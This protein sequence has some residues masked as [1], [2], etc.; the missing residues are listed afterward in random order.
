MLKAVFLYPLSLI[1]AFITG[2]RN[3]MFDYKI[4][5]SKEYDVPVISVGNITVGGTGKTPHVEYFV[6]ILKEKFKVAVLSRG[7]KRKTKGFVLANEKSDANTIGDELYQIKRKFP[8]IIVAASE[9]RRKGIEKIMSL[10]EKPDVI[11]LDDAF[12]H[13]YV[14]PGMSV[15]LIDYSKPFFAEK[16]LPYGRL[17][18]SI[19]NRDRANIIIV[20]KVLNEMKPIDMRIMSKKLKLFP[21]QS[22][23]FSGVEYGKLSPVY[24]DEHFLL[25][26]EIIKKEN[27]SILLVTGIADA[28][29]LKNKLLTISE[30][31]VHLNYQ[32]HHSYSEGDIKKIED[33]YLKITNPKK[34]IITTEKDAVKLIDSGLAAKTIREKLYYM[35]VKPLLLNSEEGDLAKQITGYV[36]KDRSISNFYHSKRQY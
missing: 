30:K 35:P 12:Q 2:F 15:L 17:R 28:K 5:K 26:E 24:K 21:Y 3:F 14:K 22:L 9:S 4:L 31:V 8:D 11:I 25:D 23:Y 7:Y 32:D 1:Y 34:L 36:S 6:S 16:F 20:T 33:E 18:E 13:R 10:P 29:H 27:Y 19:K